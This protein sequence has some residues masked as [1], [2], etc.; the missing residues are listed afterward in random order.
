[1]SKHNSNTRLIMVEAIAVVDIEMW[2]HEVQTVARTATD[3]VVIDVWVIHKFQVNTVPVVS[4]VVACDVHVVALPAM[5]SIT[6]NW[7]IRD[8]T[9]DIVVCNQ[10]ILTVLE[11]HTELILAEYTVAYGDELCIL[12]MYSTVINLWWPRWI[13]Y[14]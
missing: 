1:M 7:I 13:L 9:G 10:S 5:N 3:S 4:N 14:L 6:H 12:H 8:I 2:E 11:H